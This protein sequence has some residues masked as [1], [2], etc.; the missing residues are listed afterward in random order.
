MEHPLRFLLL[1]DSPTDAQLIADVLASDGLRVTL[2]RVEDRAAFETALLDPGFDLILSDYCLPSFDGL[3]ALAL[4]RERCPDL[5]FILV[6]GT[7]GEETAI[8]SLRAGA[9]DYVLKQR[10]SRLGPVVR[11]ALKEAAEHRQHQAAEAALRETQSLYQ[12]LVEQLPQ[13]V[14]CKDPEGRFTFVNGRFCEQTGL[15]PDQ[16]L[17]QTDFDLF[18]PELAAKYHQDDLRVMASG[19]VWTGV[20]HHHFPAAQGERIVE[21]VKWPLRASAGHVIGVQGMFWDVTEREQ[22]AEALRASEYRLNQ[23]ERLAR[24]GSWTSEL[25]PAGDGS[26]H[27]LVWSDE[28]YRIFGHKPGS[29]PVTHERF[30]EQVHPQDRAPLAAAVQEA[31]RTQQPYRIEHRVVRPDGSERLVLEQAEVVCDP[32]TGQP[33]RLMGTVQD[34][35]EPRAAE[36]RLRNL[37][38]AVEQCP[39][40]IVITDRAGNIEFVNPK[41]TRVTGYAAAEVLGRNPRLLKSGDMPAETYRRLWETVLA[42]EE[43]RGEFHNRRKDGTLFWELASISPVRGPDGEITHL[44][45]VKEDVTEKRLTEAKLLRAQ[46]VE[47]IGSLASGIAHDLNNILTPILMCAPLVAGEESAEVRQELAQTIESSAER[48]VA[49]VKQLLGFA[50]GKD[51]QRGSVQ[52]RHLIR[53]MVKITRETFPKNIQIEEVCGKDLWP[54]RADATHIHQVLLNLCVNARD[55]MPAG[56]RLVLRAENVVLDDH[57]ATMHPQAAAGPHVRLQVQDTGVGIPESV[58]EHIFESFFTTKGEG[59]GTGLGLT[60]VQG[61]VRDHGGFV[62]FTSREGRGT[63]F[64]IHLP[65]GPEAQAGQDA[66]ALPVAIPHGQGELVLVVDDEVDIRVANRRVL[67]RHGY[68]VLIARDGIEALAQF[69]DHQEEVRAIVTD[70]MMP[71]MDGLTL[72]RVLRRLRPETPVIVSSGGLFGKHGSEAL[73]GLGRLGIQQILHKPHNADLLLLTLA[74]VLRPR[75]KAPAEPPAAPTAHAASQESAPGTNPRASSAL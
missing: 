35:T 70:V 22:A 62:S 31:L 1:E 48:A 29:I 17:G 10:L 49:I 40:S 9:S 20:E 15:S 58:Q 51:G 68:R 55:A 11:R 46:R 3:T 33:A 50:R 5:P 65:A 41:F 39:V 71:Q 64:D 21:V 30:L 8:E 25:T 63:T 47:S 53:D 72:C 34:I 45:A 67:E 23:A 73:R 28:T 6:S 43:W 56:G 60:T 18:A 12:T 36:E 69:S 66:P 27:R 75:R 32:T 54:V 7:L 59:E 19:Q 13:C 24:V 4:A 52:M 26:R 37:A 42:G 38:R 61:I 74:D 44:I 14:F 16:V 2:E 57:F